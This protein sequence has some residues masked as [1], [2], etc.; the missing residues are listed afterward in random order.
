[1]GRYG[2][3]PNVAEEQSVPRFLAVNTVKKSGDLFLEVGY[4]GILFS[5]H[6]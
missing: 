5:N 6:F 2:K 3:A 4:F 1:M